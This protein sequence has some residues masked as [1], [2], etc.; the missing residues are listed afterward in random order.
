MRCVAACAAI[1]LLLLVMLALPST[2]LPVAGATGETATQL[3]ID[4]NPSG[5]TATSLGKTDACHRVDLNDTLDVDIVIKDVSE[6]LGWEIWFAYDSSRLQVTSRNVR[7]FQAAN[8]NSNVFDA[9]D[10]VPDSDGLYVA[11]AVDIGDGAQDSGSGVLARLT[12]K[13]VAPGISDLTLPQPDL[14][15]DGRIDGGPI[16]TDHNGDRIGDEDGDGFFDGK[17]TN[18][19]IAVGTECPSNPPLI[20]TPG[21]GLTP[22]PSS[23]V[24]PPGTPTQTP[25]EGTPTLEDGTPTIDG[26]PIATGTAVIIE[27]TPFIGGTPGPVSTEDFPTPDGGT[28][29][30]SKNSGDGFPWWILASIGAV[31][32][33]G[34][35]AAA[36]YLALRRRRLD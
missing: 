26:T 23:T 12:L 11:A 24:T 21:S 6:L 34:G 16:L 9:A 28:G 15:G 1:G 14:D 4:T 2:N 31:L 35:A 27:D 19:R 13:A 5:N 20:T 7:M 3:G 33:A 36:G 30:D 22:G 10:A 25:G 8:P 32:L 18:A 17:V 29:L